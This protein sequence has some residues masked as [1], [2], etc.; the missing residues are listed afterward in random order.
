MPGYQFKDGSTVTDQVGKEK[1]ELSRKND[2]GSGAAWAQDTGDEAR[3]IDALRRN[4][5]AT[6]SGTSMRGTVTHD[7]YLL[8]GLGG[9]L[10]KAHAACGM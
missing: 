8:G 7:T 6:V 4:A 5:H 9:A 1:F 10:D 3:M 2:G